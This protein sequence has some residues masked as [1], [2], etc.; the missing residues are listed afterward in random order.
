[1]SPGAVSGRYARPAVPGPQQEEQ[2]D[3]L[4]T[5]PTMWEREARLSPNIARMPGVGLSVR[6]VFFFFIIISGQAGM[7]PL[8]GGCACARASCSL[9]CESEPVPTFVRFAS[10]WLV[11]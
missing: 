8:V 11:S 10:S 7:Y 1:M 6:I 2:E 9:V 5:H 4:S 3:F